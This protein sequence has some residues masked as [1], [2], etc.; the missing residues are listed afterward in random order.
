MKKIN[1]E[2]QFGISLVIISIVLYLIHFAVFN[3]LHHIALWSLTSLAFL[4]VSV[5]FVTLLI[6]KILIRREKEMRLEKLNIIIGTF[7]SKV[8]TELLRMIINWDPNISKIK[9]ELDKS[10]MGS[11]I[12][13]DKLSELLN[14]YSYDIDIEKVEFVDLRNYLNEKNDFLLRL[15]EN[16]MTL[17]HESFTKLLR[18]VFHLSEEL[19]ARLDLTSLPQRDYLHLANDIKRAYNLIV[20]EWLDY[21]KYLEEN[22]PYLFSFSI[23]TIP[24]NPNPSPVI[25]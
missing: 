20:I 17:E 21:M 16:P 23:R 8:G 6:N 7:Y 2:M 14:Q 9:K 15:L 22:F 13:I 25:Q 19:E 4:P 11:I 18:A 1:W 5:L 12:K 10:E 3:D 24:F